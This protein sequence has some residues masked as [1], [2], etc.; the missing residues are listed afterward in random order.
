MNMKT[1]LT[2]AC[3]LGALA[4]P[5]LAQDIAAP[6]AQPD[7]RLHFSAGVDVTTAYFFRGI[8]Q[9]DDGLIVQPGFTL[10]ADLVSRD[11]FTLTLSVGSWNS[12]HGEATASQS[13]DDSVEHWYESDVI[14]SLTA[15]WEKWTVDASYIWYLSP[16]DAFE[17]IQEL[18]LSVSFDD[19]SYLGAWAMSP[20]VTLGIETGSNFADGADSDRGVYLGIGVSP[21]FETSIGHDHPLSISFPIE[22]GLSLSDYYQDG[23][24][25]DDFFGYASVGVRLETALPMPAGFGEWSVFGGVNALFLGDNL[26]TVNGDDSTEVIASIGISLTF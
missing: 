5:A 1:R 17:T 7:S 18:A 25:D 4:L 26:E 22:V 13:T 16:S 6:A 21:G 11:D 23:A 9:E 10:G 24:G 20:S 2:A 19:S 14:L 3:A 8:L 15:A 12:I